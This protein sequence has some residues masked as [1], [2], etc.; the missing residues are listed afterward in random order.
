MNTS[1]R[2]KI[3]DKHLL[4]PPLHQDAESFSYGCGWSLRATIIIITSIVIIIY[5]GM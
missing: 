4:R 5:M 3:Y 1:A 2:I